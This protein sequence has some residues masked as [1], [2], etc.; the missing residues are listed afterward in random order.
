MPREISNPLDEKL[1]TQKFRVNV[2][3]GVKSL[4]IF[5]FEIVDCRMSQMRQLL[6]TEL[7]LNENTDVRFHIEQVPS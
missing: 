3:R 5:E 4:A 6:E 1:P 7:W 2:V